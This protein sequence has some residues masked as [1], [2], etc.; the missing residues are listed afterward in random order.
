MTYPNQKT[1]IINKEP[2]NSEDEENYYTR[3][4][5]KAL[6]KAMSELRTMGE[7]KLWLYLTQNKDG[8]TLGLSAA[9]CEKYGIKIDA[10]HTAVKNLIKKGYLQ[11][12]SG[13]TY[14]FK[15]IGIPME[16]P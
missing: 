13:N 15:E 6:Q 14:I 8:L 11:H 5:L 12:K 9:T 2:C 4:N 3:I 16:K 1:V 7:I 10:Y